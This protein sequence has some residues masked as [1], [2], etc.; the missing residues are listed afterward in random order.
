M[1]S[2]QQ[3]HRSWVFTY[4]NPEAEPDM[5]DWM[6]Y[7]TFGREVG[8]SGTPHLQGA[9]NCKS[10]MTLSAIKAK[11]LPWQTVHLEPMK[12]NWRQAI[13][14]CHKDGD[15]VEHGSR[16][17]SGRRTDLEDAYE[18]AKR[19]TS[20]KDAL[21]DGSVRSWQAVRGYPALRA[22]VRPDPPLFREM[23]VMWLWGGTG[24]GK[25]VA[26]SLILGP[27]VYRWGSV[28]DGFRMA[29]DG[30]TAVLAD[31]LGEITG[32]AVQR[33]N[34]VLGG[35]PCDLRVG[36]GQVPC[37]VTHVVLTSH[38]AP[39]ELFATAGLSHR[40]PEMC[41]RLTRGCFHVTSAIAR[42]VRATDVPGS[43]L[44]A[45]LLPAG[46]ALRA[47]FHGV[48]AHPLPPLEAVPALGAA[49]QAHAW[50]ALAEAD[51][52]LHAEAAVSAVAGDV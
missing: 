29:Y 52:A 38:A 5:P 6:L 8:E 14:Y 3:R 27:G 19:N 1:A 11:G 4:N 42:V 24:L 40:W 13:E 34:Q 46:E 41:R 50:P 9:F 18:A 45:E 37:E 30:Q 16:P 51:G 21:A 15:Y 12:G 39:Q 47:F 31:D 35:G 23:R 10:A 17:K 43:T 20:L 26:G 22:A 28:T 49:F 7:L 48:P 36:G 25:T 44:S 2:A 33:L 32:P